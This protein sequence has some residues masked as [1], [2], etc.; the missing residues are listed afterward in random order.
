[1]SALDSSERDLHFQTTGEMEHRCQQLERQ[2]AK[3]RADWELGAREWKRL[4]RYQQELADWLVDNAANDDGRLIKSQINA[5]LGGEDFIPCS[6]TFSAKGRKYH[7][8]LV[9]T[10]YE[11]QEM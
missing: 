4:Q 6:F 11:I 7:M 3:Q 10:V 2:V 1:M 9:S 8:E 5:A